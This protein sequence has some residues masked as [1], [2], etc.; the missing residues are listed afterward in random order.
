VVLQAPQPGPFD[1]DVVFRGLCLIRYT[2]DSGGRVE[3]YFNQGD[4]LKIEVNR[5]LR[6][7]VSNAGSLTGRIGNASLALGGA[8]EIATKLIRWEAAE[9]GDSYELRVIPVY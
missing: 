3:R 8:G 1:V 5:E 4:V 2:A 6:L 9:S 7:W